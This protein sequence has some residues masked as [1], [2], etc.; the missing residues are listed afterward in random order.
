ARYPPSVAA[1][2][3]HRT[4]G[5]AALARVRR[6]LLGWYD[7]EQRDFP[8]RRTS[9]PWAVLVSE[10]MLQQ[11]QASRV[12]DRFPPFLDRFPSAAAMAEASEAEVLVAWSGLGYNRRVLALRRTAIAIAR[13]GWPRDV[14]ALER[15][16]GIG[17]YTA[18]AVASLAFGE[19]VGVVDTNVRRWLVRRFGLP[20]DARPAKLQALA[21][22][23]A[24][25]SEH[26]PQ[27]A[28]WTHATMEFGARICRSRAP[29]C[30][31]CPIASGCP[32]RGVA[33]AVPVPRQAAF[34]RSERAA[35]GALLKRLVAAPRQG[36]SLAAAQRVVRELTDL[37]FERIASGLERDRLAHRSGGGLRLGGR[38]ADA[39][40][41]TIGP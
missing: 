30:G 26:V 12:V 36:L 27:T 14:A 13:D 41:A 9:D 6:C 21:D 38:E 15:L 10:V 19:P 18:R 40:A 39:G 35:R 7:A 32:S 22:R 25:P 8:W 2:H 5:D 28:A 16:P 23:L 34:A 37:D 11:T 4:D 33:G 29:R 3:S 1:T 17:P 31:A 24:Q 20:T